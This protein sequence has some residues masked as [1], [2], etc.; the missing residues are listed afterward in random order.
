MA[1]VIVRSSIVPATVIVALLVKDPSA[2]EVIIIAGGMVSKVTLIISE[3]PVFP[4]K[5]AALTEIVFS[6]S[7]KVIV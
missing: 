5:S 6:P 7:D 3:L 2:G 4:A 1:E